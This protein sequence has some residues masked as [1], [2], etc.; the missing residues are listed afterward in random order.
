MRNVYYPHQPF[1]SKPCTRC[2]RVPCRSTELQTGESDIS[3][4]EQE[5]DDNSP[6]LE[7]GSETGI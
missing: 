5:H 7:V 4:D 6:N 1:F 2:L 3:E